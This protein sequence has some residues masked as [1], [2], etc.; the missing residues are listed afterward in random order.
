MKGPSGQRAVCRSSSGRGRAFQPVP[1]SGSLMVGH[2][3]LSVGV[4]RDCAIANRNG[5][6]RPQPRRSRLRPL[7]AADEGSGDSPAQ[8][9]PPEGS[10]TFA[11]R[12][13]FPAKGIERELG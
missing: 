12:D 1:H 7:F 4:H 3:P 13:K 8:L 5:N 2:D 11:A 6:G 9:T 10:G